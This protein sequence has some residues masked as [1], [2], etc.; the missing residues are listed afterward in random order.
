M[1]PFI[2]ISLYL[3]F[4]LNVDTLY[5]SVIKEGKYSLYSFIRHLVG[6]PKYQCHDEQIDLRKRVPSSSIHITSAPKGARTKKILA[7]LDE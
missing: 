5:G 4:F 6:L 7:H 3:T 1:F 2:N